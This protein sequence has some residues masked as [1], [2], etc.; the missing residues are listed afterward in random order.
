MAAQLFKGPLIPK[1]DRRPALAGVLTAG[2]ANLERPARCG[3]VA[4]LLVS[5]DGG[6]QKEYGQPRN[7][8]R[9]RRYLGIVQ[10]FFGNASVVTFQSVRGG[11]PPHREFDFSVGKLAPLFDD[12]HVTAGG[13]C[14][15]KFAR[16]SARVLKGKGEGLAQKAIAIEPAKVAQFPRSIGDVPRAFHYG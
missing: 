4:E 6:S 8:A 1:P 15:K 11:Q 14:V 10:A 16:L 5:S 12:R 7:Q 3:M 9:N 2:P 13:E